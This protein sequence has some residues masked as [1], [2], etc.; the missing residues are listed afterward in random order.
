MINKKIKKRRFLTRVKKGSLT[1]SSQFIFGS[2]KNF[3]YQYKMKFKKILIIKVLTKTKQWEKNLINDYLK[4]S[5]SDEYEI[6][7]K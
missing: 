2:Q 1:A 6:Y 4:D 5:I 3:K 7:F